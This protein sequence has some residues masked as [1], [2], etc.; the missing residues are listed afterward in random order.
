MVAYVPGAIPRVA[1]AA[2]GGPGSVPAA[3][4]LATEG[5]G[6]VHV[7]PCAAIRT[8]RAT[9]TLPLPELRS[10]GTCGQD[11]RAPRGGQLGTMN[12]EL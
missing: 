2:P 7:A 10:C 5:R 4:R 11:A 6:N 12:R 1:V 3:G 8:V 9:R